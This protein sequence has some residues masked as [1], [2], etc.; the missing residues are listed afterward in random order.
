V[1]IKYPEYQIGARVV[2]IPP[3]EWECP[4]C[5]RYYSEETCKRR[6][7]ATVIDA[8]EYTGFCE[9]CGET[10]GSPVIAIEFDE[11]WVTSTGRG[12][13]YAVS[14]LWLRPLDP[15]PGHGAGRDG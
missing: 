11:A 14:P 9:A 4:K 10:L 12:R 5:G 13:I 7:K 2:F 8:A 1:E 3:A 15:K 6:V